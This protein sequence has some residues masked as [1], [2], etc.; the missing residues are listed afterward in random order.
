MRKL[1]SI[2]RPWG[3][4]ILCG[5]L[6]L[7]GCGGAGGGST[8]SPST[9][10]TITPGVGYNGSTAPLRARPTFDVSFGSTSFRVN[11]D[12]RELLVSVPS[13]NVQPGDEFAVSETQAIVYYIESSTTGNGSVWRGDGG[14][15]RIGRS[16]T[17]EFQSTHLSPNGSAETNGNPALGT[18]QLS[19]TIRGLNL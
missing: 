13:T 9:N 12:N 3:I 16:R 1:L 18:L 7:A 17:L 4:A 8:S 2:T 5:S 11:Q 10:V 15:V 14:T 19:G 6:V